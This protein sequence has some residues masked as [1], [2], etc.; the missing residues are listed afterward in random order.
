ME[1][2]Q[3]GQ[4]TQN[5]LNGFFQSVGQKDP[6][7]V[8]LFFAE[9]VNFYIAESRYMPWTGKRS[10]R[11]E[12]AEALHLLFDAHEDGED[13]FDIDHLFIDGQEAAVF[14]H[15]GRKVKATGKKFFAPVCQRFTIKNGLIT[16]FLML[17]DAHA[18]EE[19]FINN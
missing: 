7:A 15:A 9:D 11:S 1:L 10:K 18:I 16:R 4:E 5:I 12:V 19:A 17:E 8:A 13:Q 3:Q 2:S 6:E 14:G